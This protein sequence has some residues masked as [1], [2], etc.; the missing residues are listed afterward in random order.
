LTTASSPPSH[1]GGG[2]GGIG[3][4]LARARHWLPDA[5]LRL[6]VWAVCRPLQVLGAAEL[7]GLEPP[8]LLVANHASHL[9]TPLVLT[10]LPP[11]L[12]RR[13]AVAAA[14]D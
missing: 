9:D 10:A 4:F 12:R 13:T 14:A 6:L 7:D 3:P 2:A 1:S 11:A 5:A 8:F